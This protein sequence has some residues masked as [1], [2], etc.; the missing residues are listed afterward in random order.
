MKKYLL[1]LCLI[2]SS[3][4]SNN[5]IQEYE[6]ALKLEE[7]GKLLEAMEIYKKIAK[8]NL[9]N[10]D[11]YLLNVKDTNNDKQTESFTSMKKNFYQKQIDKINDNETDESIKQI[12]VGDFDLYP[13]EKNYLLPVTYDLQ[14]NSDGRSKF[15][16][17]FQISVEKPISY[18]FFGLNE[19]ISGAYTQ[20]SFWQ[21]SK[22]SSPFRETNY[23]PEVFVM[24]PYT[25]SETLKAIKVS[26]LHESNGRNNEFSRSWNRI[27]AQ[28]FFQLS[29]LF[30]SPKVWYRIPEKSNDDD[31]PDIED[32]YGYGDLTLLYAYKKHTFELNLRNNLKFSENN[33]GAVDFNWAFPLP[34][35]LSTKNSYGMLN[36]F[37]G[38]GNNLIDYNEEVNKIGL[39]IAFSR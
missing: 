17:Q 13:Y 35:F 37:S 18:D 8:N 24:F 10:E 33:K 5:Q 23:K 38:Y 32:Y 4:Y 36:I 26:V 9:S 27:Y 6:K 39:G 30:I 20:K 14:N 2:I 11:K 12:T 31:N 19:T 16:T 34:S 21:T 7:E 3:V 22:E 1:L 29:N 25:N 15:E 28:G